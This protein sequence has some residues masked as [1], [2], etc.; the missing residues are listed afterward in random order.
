[1][2]VEVLD[3]LED[4]VVLGDIAAAV[5]WCGGHFVCF[6]VSVLDVVIQVI[7]LK[8]D[9]FPNDQLRGIRRKATRQGKARVAGGICR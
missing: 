3:E 8:E 5:G 2:A 6:S 7:F 4:E 1:M 9:C